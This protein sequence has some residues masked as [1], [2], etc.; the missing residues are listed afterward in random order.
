MPKYFGGTHVTQMIHGQ[1]IAKRYR[2]DKLYYQAFLDVGFVMWKGPNGFISSYADIEGAPNL[3]IPDPNPSLLV[4]Q[5]VPLNQPITKLKTG[6]TINV[7]LNALVLSLGE[8]S[9]DN[10]WIT[11]SYTSFDAGTKIITNT[12][13]LAD[14]KSRTAVKLA[15]GAFMD[16]AVVAVDDTHLKFF[17]QQNSTTAP[18]EYQNSTLIGWN[19][20]SSVSATRAFLIIDSITAY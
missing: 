8:Y 3:A 1:K 10:R 12:I 18:H 19:D 17:N 16:I 6:L 20:G 9:Y 7:D 4:N 14:L 5:S 15:T 11:E 13:S 2:G